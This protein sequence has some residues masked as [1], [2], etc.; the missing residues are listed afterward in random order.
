MVQ[1][2]WQRR[3]IGTAL[4]RRLTAYAGGAGLAALVAHVGV[5]NA[6]MLRTLR[7]CGADGGE[8]DGTMLSV[9]LPVAGRR[10]TE[11]SATRR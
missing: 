2:D 1:D 10:R 8:R 11:T 3:G 6:A 4:L 5:D 7:R 9:T